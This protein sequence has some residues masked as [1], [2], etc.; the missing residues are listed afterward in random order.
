MFDPMV[1][2]AYLGED[3]KKSGELSNMTEIIEKFIDIFEEAENQVGFIDAQEPTTNI[4]TIVDNK[5]S[6]EQMHQ[7]AESI[8]TENYVDDL[9][10]Q[11]KLQEPQH[12]TVEAITIETIIQVQ[13][14]AQ[15]QAPQQ[16]QPK[17]SD[18]PA[19][20]VDNVEQQE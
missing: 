10:P 8:E 2:I 11:A 4:K 5:K 9:L 13:L 3:K 14:S 1:T 12:Q 16:Q 15:Q 17:S 19:K 6:D 7:I 18:S 20:M